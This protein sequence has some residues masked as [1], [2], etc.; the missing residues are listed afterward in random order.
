M[1]SLISKKKGNKLYYY[2]VESARVDGQPR[3][4]QQTY[5]GTAEKL[6]ALLKDRT[7]PVPVSASLREFGLPR[8]LAGCSAFRSVDGAGI[9]VAPA[10]LWPVDSPLCAAG[11]HSPDLSTGAEDGGGRLV[12]RHDLTSAVEVSTGT[13]SFPGLLGLF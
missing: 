13:F 1:A 3:I 5:L 12:W 7:A 8:T 11:C 9:D 2:V 10:A 4:V 6:A